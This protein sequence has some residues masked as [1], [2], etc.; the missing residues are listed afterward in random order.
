MS[1]I[2][3]RISLIAAFFILA[4]GCA[5]SPP[6]NID[7]TNKTAVAIPGGIFVNEGVRI[8][9]E[10]GSFELIG[11]ERFATPFDVFDWTH[12]VN[13]FT[14]ES[15]MLEHYD[16]ALRNGAKRVL[17]YQDGYDKPLYGVLVFNQAIAAAYGPASRSYM[18]QI[19][20]SKIQAARDGVTA[21]TW[22]KMQW[23]QT[24]T[25]S[26]DQNHNWYAWSLWL[27]TY[28]L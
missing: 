19:P 28:P 20:D 2:T 3:K 17:I 6:P 8:V 13:A 16:M 10:D 24:Y 9:A 27:S 7:T 14:K 15:K 4:L 11:G 22:E 12:A 23:K 18:L 5:S 1:L 25:R 21:V 26:A